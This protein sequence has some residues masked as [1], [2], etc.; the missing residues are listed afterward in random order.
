MLIAIDTSG[1]VNNNELKEF[2]NEIHHVHKAGVDISII[3]CDTE[4][5]SIDDYNGDFT[6][7]VVG[8]GG[9]DFDPVLKY[10]EQ[11]K[12]YTSLI[13][14]TD[15]ECSTSIKPSKPILWVLSEQ[16]STNEGLPGR[17]IKLE[18]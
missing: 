5:R 6:L 15:G 11:H 18:L 2:M 12:E 1:S 4:I 10:F 14:F 13:Y 9:T 3:Q 8:R 7:N 16:S 17:V